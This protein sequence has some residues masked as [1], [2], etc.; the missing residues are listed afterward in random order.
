MRT[1]SPVLVLSISQP[2]QAVTKAPA[3]APPT[4][5]WSLS[6]DQA[7]AVLGS[8]PEGL[9]DA[10]AA[11]RL[12]TYGPNVLPEPRATPAV[13]VFL[14][15]FRSP[16]IYLLLAERAIEVVADRGLTRHV[17]A[18]QWAQLVERMRAAFAAGRFE[19]GLAQAVDEVTALLVRHFP[20]A[21]GEA[22]P[23]ELP[24][25]PVLG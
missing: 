3:A 5:F 10:E 2:G 13:L 24:D 14:R 25:E 4:P 12:K 19:E 17:D 7:L 23:N 6:A 8:E 21:P 15:Q 9:S 20:L 16:L 18:G 1:P 22:N 11:A